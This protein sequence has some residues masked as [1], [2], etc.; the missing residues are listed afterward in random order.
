MYHRQARPAD[1]LSIDRPSGR[2]ILAQAV[3]LSLVIPVYNE[4]AT[5]REIIQRVVAVDVD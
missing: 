5:L 4:V 1:A 3:K 2:V